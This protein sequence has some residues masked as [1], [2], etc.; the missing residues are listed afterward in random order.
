MGWSRIASRCCVRLHVAGLENLENAPGLVVTV[1][2]RSD[3][4]GVIIPPVF[5]RHC[6]GTGPV[7]R[8]AF[9]SGEHVFQRGFMAGYVLPRPRWLHPLL[10]RV[11]VSGVVR[12]FRFYPIP[13]AKRRFLAAHLNDLLTAAGDLPLRDVLADSPEAVFPGAPDGATIRAVYRSRYAKE[14]FTLHDPDAF[15]PEVAALLDTRQR[16]AIRESL[17]V[18]ARVLDD[19]DALFIAPEGA[20][21]PDGRIGRI[22]SGLRQIVG[23][24]SRAT[25]LLPVCVTYDFM[26]TGRPAAYLRIGPPIRDART[27]PDEEWPHRVRRL[28]A[29]ETTVTFSQ[30]AGQYVLEQTEAHDGPLDM[31]AMKAAL[32]RRAANCAAHGLHVAEALL[33]GPAFERRWARFLGYCR[34]HALREVGNGVLAINNPRTTPARHAVHAR[35]SPW[36]YAANELNEAL[37]AHKSA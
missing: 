11:S 19:G 27:W 37:E 7:G 30:L 4:D 10:F 35:V 26:T 23:R 31:A 15:R 20:L 5:H 13:M 18:F 29:R 22:K 9:V 3:L 33:Q 1:C 36:V 6:R 8:C 17:D 28:L 2:H 14:L 25:T 24:A 16:D 34:R 12:A 21:S 32:T